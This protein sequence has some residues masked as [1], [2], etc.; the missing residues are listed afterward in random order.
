MQRPVL[1]RLLCL[2]LLVA[3]LAGAADPPR[4]S[5]IESYRRQDPTGRGSFHR[6]GLFRELDN[7]QSLAAEAGLEPEPTEQ[8]KA[9]WAQSLSKMLSMQFR[10]HS[11]LFA[12]DNIFNTEQ[13]AQSDSQF[14]QFVGVSLDAQLSEHWK[15]GNSFDQAWFLHGKSEN[16][17]SDFVT[18]TFR[19]A[20]SYDRY[21]FNNKVGL[22]VPLSWQF[23]RLSNRSTGN[24]T[25]DTWSYGAAT[26]F[27]WFLSEKVI[28]TFSYQYSFQDSGSPQGPVSDKHKHD[29]NLGLT[30]IPIPDVRFYVIPS[31]QYS[32]EH[33][34]QAERRDNAW[35]PTLTL[36]WQPLGFLA[37][38]AVAS[39]TD[40]QSTLRNSSF[41]ALTGTLFVRLFYNW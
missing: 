41:D 32:H 22:T 39:H 28:P 1:S 9:G 17:G 4:L 26:E 12:S 25:L 30:L 6:F 14:A 19:Q 5:L 24:R 11:M 40:S 21:L 35:T 37:V 34:S 7:S 31:V 38:D 20:L 10:A 13:D 29:L 8:E 16:S 2:S 36:S 27:S 23:S 15:L 33:F 3:P 18:S